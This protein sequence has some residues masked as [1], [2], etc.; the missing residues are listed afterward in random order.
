MRKKVTYREAGVDV[1][2][3]DRFVDLIR[4][5]AASTY[6]ENVVGGVGGFSGFYSLPI[7]GYRDPV[8]V[9]ATDGV[10]TKLKIAFLAGVFDTIGIDLV[11]MCVNDVV[12]SGARPLFF[13][14]YFATSK[15]SLEVGVGVVRGIAEGC[16]QAG[17]AL[18]GGETAEM[19]GFY[20]EGEFDIA[21][22]AV[23]IVDREDL[24]HPSKVKSGDKVVGLASS[25]LH[26]NGYSLVRRVLIE[27]MKIGLGEVPPSF[28]RTLGDTLLTPTRIYAK[29]ILALLSSFDIHGIAHITGG[30]L[31]GNIP[32]VIPPQYSVVLDSSSWQVPEV[33]RFIQEASGLGWDEMHSVFNCGIGMA[34]IVREDEV[35]DIVEKA[36]SLG[37]RAF[38]IGEV[39]KR[40]NGEPPIVIE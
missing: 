11:A 12:T 5:L 7:G 10:G 6:D 1:E 27:D 25:G 35:H 31:R 29:T 39:R 34:L 3:G 24:I 20:G 8:L 14:D 32:R 17:C 21:G 28:D 33:F 15:L 37:D 18:L 38:I 23:G 26:S 9:S 36:I 40:A 16:R 22:F 2:A 13:L 19:P 30:G 4:P